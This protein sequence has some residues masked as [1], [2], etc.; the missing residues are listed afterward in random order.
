M[1]LHTIKTIDDLALLLLHKP[2]YIHEVLGGTK[3]LDN[4]ASLNQAVAERNGQIAS[5]SQA[6]TERDGQIASL[7]QA[8]TERDGQIASL[9]Q[10]VTSATG[11]SPA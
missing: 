6:V 11:R 9:S 8:V 4:I 2:Q 3:V 7:S 10:A 5:Y 1:Q